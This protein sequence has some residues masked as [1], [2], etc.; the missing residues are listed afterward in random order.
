M[1]GTWTAVAGL[2]TGLLT[3][4]ITWP[5]ARWLASLG[6]V[7]EPNHRSMHT[8]AFPRGGG[9]GI[10]VATTAVTMASIG[11][12]LDSRVMATLGASLG[13]AAVG[14]A[15][16]R[17]NLAATP[18]L[19]AQ[20]MVA[21][22]AIVMVNDTTLNV[23]S[24]WPF[25]PAA[26]ITT[27]W[28][29]GCCNSINFMDG[30]AAITGLH[31]IVFGGHLLLVGYD[32]ELVR[33]PAALAIGAALGFLYWNAYR[34]KVFL[35]DGGAYFVGAYFALLV[36]LAS[37]GPST[38]LIAA[39]PFAVYAADTAIAFT[40]RVARREQLTEG[41][42]EHV[43]QRLALQGRRHISIAAFTA[44][45]SAACGAAAIAVDRDLV[46]AAAGGALFVAVLSLYL[47]A[48]RWMP[49]PHGSG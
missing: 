30:I 44:A 33:L 23:G 26:I 8:G 11:L 40:R 5:L 20:L 37:I 18:R 14:F 32:D 3:L 27:A 41:H 34:E 19:L 7:A 24:T 21:A 1:T 9:A 15:D 13:L 29:L 25:L 10:A 35:G 17:F 43:Y 31:M 16:D 36:V 6:L 45:C 2:A 12:G 42:R 28:V 48:P 39:A 49:S 22:V 47:S 38:P 46:P 4:A